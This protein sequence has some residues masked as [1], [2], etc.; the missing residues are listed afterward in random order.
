AGALA[1]AGPETV[2]MLA[3]VGAA[4]VLAVMQKAPLFAAVIAWELTWAPLWT[5]P[6]LLLGAVVAYLLGHRP[7]RRQAEAAPS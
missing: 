2:P 5:I 7:W 4:M 3:L 1:G 6:L